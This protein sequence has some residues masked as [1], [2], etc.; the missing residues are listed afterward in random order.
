MYVPCVDL[1]GACLVK[2][3]SRNKFVVLVF[4]SFF[5]KNQ[6]VFNTHAYEMIRSVNQK[7]N[8]NPFCSLMQKNNN[9]NII[10]VWFFFFNI[11]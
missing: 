2:E 6:V 8:Q 3:D 9:N 11:T 7:Y 10:I 5:L 4:S 1:R